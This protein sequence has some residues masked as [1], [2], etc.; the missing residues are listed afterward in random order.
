MW[1]FL[2]ALG[3]LWMS[4]NEKKMIASLTHLKKV[5]F[6]KVENNSGT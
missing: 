4:V 3:F 5:V 2:W 6:R 1:A